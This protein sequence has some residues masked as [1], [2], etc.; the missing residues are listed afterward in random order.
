M[1]SSTLSRTS[2]DVKPRALGAA[3]LAGVLSGPL[4]WLI[5][6]E[7]AY[8]ASYSV[9]GA[10]SQLGLHL[11]VL[12]PLLLVAA[13]AA[14]IEWIEGWPSFGAAGSWARTMADAGLWLCFWFAIV[15]LATEVPVL[16]LIPC[17]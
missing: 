6:L 10:E 16:A 9:C 3:L 11:A 8:V 17:R 15:V 13:G 4:A 12:A 14:L 5:S 2:G 1:S 7:A